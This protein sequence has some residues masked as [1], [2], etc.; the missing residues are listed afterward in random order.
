[1][2]A[3]Q[4]QARREK[5]LQADPGSRSGYRYADLTDTPIEIKRWTD[6]PGD[7][8]VLVQAK[9]RADE[10]PAL[11]AVIISRDDE[12]RIARAVSS[13]VGQ[14][15]PWPF[16]VI[17][18]TSGTD[19]TAEI[20]RRE[21]PQVTLVELPRPALPGE[22]RN[23]GLRIARGDYVSFPGS[24]VEL[25]QGSLAARIEAHD[26]GYAMVTGTT[27]NGTLTRAGWATYF[28]DHSSVL[29]GRP[30]TPLS[31]PPAHC[32]YLREALL[33]VG[34]FP[35]TIRA[36]EDTVVNN[37]L[38]R[39]GYQAYRAREV[40]LVHHSPCRTTGRLL[41]HHFVRGRGYGRILLDR[42]R[43]RGTL[44][45]THGIRSL[46][47]IQVR[48][49][50]EYTARRVRDWGGDELQQEFARARRLVLAATFAYWLGTC[51]ELF[52]PERAKA[53]L[54]W[55]KP[56]VTVGSRGTIVRVD[57]VARRTKVVHLPDGHELPDGTLPLDGQLRG[58][59]AVT[60]NRMSAV[61]LL[62]EA[63][64]DARSRLALAWAA[65]VVRPNDVHE[66][67]LDIGADDTFAEVLR[68]ALDT[69]GFRERA[70]PVAAG[71]LGT[72]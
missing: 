65:L 66:I 67:R 10:A 49:R 29:P 37:E 25:P 51:Y 59:A 39:R 31:G 47:R 2:T 36:G 22:A 63:D 3:T 26:L 6:R 48:T 56:V 53:L 9:D 46:F 57:V 14:E 24:H 12:T 58:D 34:G 38:A 45:R 16:E 44:L 20:V 15:S 54:L 62:R 33:E 17:V 42:R 32:S 7:A 21:F 8:P 70:T 11:S 13:V 43:Y 35:E 68:R 1:L 61:R 69:R 50:M 71:A 40:R 28:L 18:V 23:A 4:R 30:S 60:D 55:G 19:K 5:Y 64:V 52:R 72:R 41:R 27:L